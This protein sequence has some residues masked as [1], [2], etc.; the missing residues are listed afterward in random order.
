MF[1][2]LLGN[3]GFDDG[4]VSRD[5]AVVSLGAAAPVVDAVVVGFEAVLD[6][7]QHGLGPALDP[8]LRYVERM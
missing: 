3:V 5:L 7:P 2:D 8:I 1:G 6:S 4:P